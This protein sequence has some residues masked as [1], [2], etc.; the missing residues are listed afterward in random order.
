LYSRRHLSVSIPAAFGT[1]RTK[2]AVESQAVL[3]PAARLNRYCARTTSIE[4]T[5]QASFSTIKSIVF[6][7]GC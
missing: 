2:A 3:S 7:Q 4:M 5:E 6:E 1:T